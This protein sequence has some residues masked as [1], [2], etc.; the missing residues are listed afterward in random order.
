MVIDDDIDL[1][2]L[3]KASLMASGFETIGVN[4]SAAAIDMAHMVQPDIF[5]I[6]MMMPAL[7]GFQLCSL[8]RRDRLL[9]K[10][11]I[12]VVTAL[13][14][15]DSQ[16]AAMNAGANTFITKP[17]RMDELKAKIADLLKN[18]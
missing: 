17:F 11:P 13:T 12:I 14:D 3:Y 2:N 4:Q 1:I 10:T 8:L 9:H 18:T 5:V 15:K 16:A 7:D 6:D